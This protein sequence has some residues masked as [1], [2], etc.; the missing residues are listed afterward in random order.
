[1][2]PCG[3]TGCPGTPAC[4]PDLVRAMDYGAPGVP[5]DELDD[6]IRPR[7]RLLN[8]LGFTTVGSCQGGEG[9]AFDLPAVILR[10]GPSQTLGEL[11]G[12]LA[13]RLIRTGHCGFQVEVVY[14]YQQA[15][16]PWAAGSYVR[17]VFWDRAPPSSF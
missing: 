5:W 11:A 17:V 8:R 2:C 12:R 10:P 6:E 14:A 15:P 16:Q 1:M 3:K 4:F 9:H 13:H 7:V